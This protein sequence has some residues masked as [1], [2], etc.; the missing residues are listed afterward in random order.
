MTS[1]SRRMTKREIKTDYFHWLCEI[2]CV[3]QGEESFWFLAK[4]LHNIPYFW[5]V[6]NDDNRGMDGLRL[7]DE[8][9]DDNPCNGI[10]GVIFNEPCT[11]LEM[12]VGLARRI[13]ETM[14]EP[15]KDDQTPKWFWEMMENSTLDLYTDALY[16]DMNGE[17]DVPKIVMDI[18]DRRY[19][20]DGKGGL[21]PLKFP[22]KDQRRVEI[23]YQMSTYLV[24]NY[25]IEREILG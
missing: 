19:K 10:A 25:F 11:M 4:A 13:E 22:K 1:I 9:V 23:W 24:E 6:P 21:F 3:D 17:R 16:S 8:Y 12:L 2:I 7:R 20:R 15:G 14:A 18:L 5:T